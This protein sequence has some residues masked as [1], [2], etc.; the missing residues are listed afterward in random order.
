MIRGKPGFARGC[1]MGAENLLLHV[2]RALVVMV[3]ETGFADG[4]A[5]RMPGQRDQPIGRHIR[6]H[7]GIVRM[8]AD[9][10]VNALM[11]LGESPIGVEACH[12][13]RDGH[14]TTDAGRSGSRQNLGEAALKI[15]EIQVAMAVDQHR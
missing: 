5:A 6:L 8:R 12:M 13:G 7:G 3:V 1:D 2:A 10:E 11:G 4:Y 14:H 9:C 15:R